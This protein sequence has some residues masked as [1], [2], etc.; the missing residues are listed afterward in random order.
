MRI[1]ILHRS[2]YL[3]LDLIKSTDQIYKTRA[4]IASTIYITLWIPHVTKRPMCSFLLLLVV[5]RIKLSRLLHSFSFHNFYF[6]AMS[7]YLFTTIILGVSCER[8][9]WSCFT[10]T[11]RSVRELRKR[12]AHLDRIRN[13]LAVCISS[14]VTKLQLHVTWT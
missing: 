6:S 3:F 2:T 10:Y 7:T 11:S 1:K 4:K 9:S 5:G 13:C 14:C 12:R 8:V